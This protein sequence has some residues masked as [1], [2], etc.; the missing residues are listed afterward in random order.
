MPVHE[1]LEIDCIRDPSGFAELREPWNRLASAMRRP[2][3]FLFHEWFQAAWEWAGLDSDL[4]VLRIRD[5]DRTI[6]FFPLLLRR[7]PRARLSA[8]R[9]EFLSVP[10]TQYCDLICRDSDRSACLRAVAAYLERNAPAWEVMV[11]RYLAQRSPTVASPTDA[12]PAHRIRFLARSGG[13]NPYVDL[14]GTWDAFYASRS[15]RMKKG[16]NLAAGRL[17]R[18]G[19]I[20]VEWFRSSRDDD[21]RLPMVLDAITHISARSWKGRTPF[22]LDHPGPG[23]FIRRLSATALE[24]GWLSIW[25]LYLSEEPVA[26][27]YQLIHGDT[28]HALRADFDETCAQLSPGTYLNWKILEALFGTGLSRYYMGPGENAYKL[29]WSTTGDPLIT[30]HS[31]SPSLRGRALSIWDLDLKPRLRRI[32]AAS[33]SRAGTGRGP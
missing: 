10:D 22:S 2:R 29:R 12:L 16:N 17:R 21:H 19:E 24:R 32:R 7:P 3:V 8:R 31:Y 20:R 18:A 15:R 11:L 30:A 26:M 1:R 13:T 33:T 25:I 28:V 23:A 9:L 5:A 6:G 14:D 27:E 4:H